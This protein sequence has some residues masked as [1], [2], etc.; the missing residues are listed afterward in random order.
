MGVNLNWFKKYGLRCSERPWECSVNSK[1]V[2]TDKWPFYDHVWPFF[3][4]Y[5]VIFHKTEIQT[6]I[7]RCLRSLNL[8]WFQSYDK[9]SK[10]QI[11]PFP[12]FCNFFKKQKFEFLNFW[13]LCH[14]CFTNQ[15]LEGPTHLKLHKQQWFDVRCHDFYYTWVLLPWGPINKC[16]NCTV[17][18]IFLY[19]PIM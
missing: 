1:N 18:F 4:K 12:V 9:Y 14:N 16:I 10:T 3:T 6:V 2:A 7:L 13:V 11:F 15:D 19:T 5:M 17:L 8:N